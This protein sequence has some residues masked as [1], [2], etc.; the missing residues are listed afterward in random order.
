MTIISTGVLKLWVRDVR[1]LTVLPKPEGVLKHRDPAPSAELGPR[2]DRVTFVRRAY[3]VQRLV[4]DHMIDER[5]QMRARYAGVK[6]KAVRARSIKRCASTG[7]RLALIGRWYRRALSTS[8]QPSRCGPWC[9]MRATTRSCAFGR[10]DIVVA[11]FEGHP[12]GMPRRC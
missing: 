1:G 2:G 12:A 6:R 5:L 8:W 3:I 10:G 7:S 4:I 11:P 9:N